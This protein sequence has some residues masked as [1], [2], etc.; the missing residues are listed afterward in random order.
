MRI[1]I[2][3]MRVEMGRKEANLGRALEAIAQAAAHG[4]DAVVLP[5]CPYIGWLCERAA[6]L[7]EP[8][9]GDISRRLADAARSHGLFVCSGLTER[10]G[11]DVYN[12]ALLF[13]RMG[14]LAAKHR[15][16][17]ELEVG[18]RFY[19][20]GRSLEVVDSALGLVGVNICADNWVPFIVQTLCRMGAWLVLAPC[21][22]ACDPGQEQANSGT[23]RKRFRNRTSE[24]AVVL[25]GAN[26]V[27]Q[28][29]EGPWEGRVL[30]GRSL[31]YGPGGR[32]LLAGE[33]NREQVLYCDVNA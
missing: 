16:I 33:L 11:E 21:A 18:L 7:A 29:T 22:W 9:P 32:E 2:V 10:D 25:A 15:K 5:E 23:I 13:D 28:L 1:A 12:S 30:H 19:R 27:G 20:R 26:A 24:S 14:R 4:A 17:N 8:V 31:V 3:Q 6:D